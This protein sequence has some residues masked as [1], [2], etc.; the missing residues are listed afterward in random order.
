MNIN[1]FFNILEIIFFIF[2]IPLFIYS[3]KRY[4]S[5]SISMFTFLGFSE[6]L[7]MSI[8]TYIIISIGNLSVINLTILYFTYLILQLYSFD[9]IIFDKESNVNNKFNRNINLL[10]LSNMV[11][12]TLLV[13]FLTA[14]L[15]V[16]Y[17]YNILLQIYDINI[18]RL[19][20]TIII[21]LII[22]LNIFK[23]AY[24]NKLLKSAYYKIGIVL[25]ITIAV[26]VTI[27]SLIMSYINSI[28]YYKILISF[29]IYF[30]FI[31]VIICMFLVIKHTKIN[32][33]KHV[34]NILDSLSYNKDINNSFNEVLKKNSTKII[35]NDFLSSVL[36]RRCG[37]NSIIKYC[38]KKKFLESDILEIKNFL[39]LN[40]MRRKYDFYYLPKFIINIIT[41]RKKDNKRFCFPY[42]NRFFKIF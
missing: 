17:Y 30:N 36:I 38:V 29:T 2:S 32:L 4:I 13:L 34:T 33:F 21:Y 5:Q 31:H 25:Y 16:N 15:I 11:K 12:I 22:F 18:Y 14:V 39:K 37:Y 20:L 26:F 9:D 23:I 19:I 40:L 28:I 1:I 8:T 41:F 7:A 6:S 24:F 27:S 35:L 3:L 42:F 10:Y